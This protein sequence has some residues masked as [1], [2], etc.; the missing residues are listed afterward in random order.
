MRTTLKSLCFLLLL[1]AGGV[2]GAWAE[3]YV[4]NN[5][6]ISTN[7]T[8]SVT[9]GS[10]FTISNT[11]EKSYGNVSDTEYI[12]YSS[13]ANHTLSGIPEGE[14]IVSIKFEG[15][16]NNDESEANLTIN[17]ETQ[18]FPV[19][20]S[21][22]SHTW[23][24]TINSGE[25]L[26]FKPTKEGCFVI[27]VT[28]ESAI[29][30][31][32]PNN[33]VQTYPYTWDLSAS[34]SKWST[35]SIQLERYADWGAEGTSGTY[36]KQLYPEGNTGPYGYD[37]DVIK[38]LRFSGI[39]FIGLD[40]G[41]G[42]I[43]MTAGNITIPGLTAGQVVTL[44]MEGRGTGATTVTA[45]N[46]TEGSVSVA[47]SEDN[48][49]Y[50][51][52]T[53]TSNGDVTLSFNN[54]VSIRS[55]AV[56]EDKVYKSKYT[57][58]TSTEEIDGKIRNLSGTFEFIGDG[59]IEGGTQITDVP[60]IVMTVGRAE[61]T[62]SVEEENGVLYSKTNAATTRTTTEATAG[63]F[64]KFT[65]Y[66]NGFITLHGKS[67]GGRTIMCSP[68]AT[69]TT[70]S[71]IELGNGGVFNGNW[72]LSIPLIAGKTYYFVGRVATGEDAYFYLHGF[73]FRPAFL[74]VDNDGN[75]T[76]TE[77]S[78]AVASP[79]DVNMS[80]VVDKYPKLITP[81]AGE[82]LVKFAGSRTIV[83]LKA[84]N[85]VTLL[86]EG[87]TIIKGTVLKND[88]SGDELFTYY[89]LKS[90]VLKLN[91]EFEDQ[92]YIDDLGSDGK[93]EFKN[94]K[95]NSTDGPMT[96]A[97]GAKVYIQ[98]GADDPVEYTL[99]TSDQSTWRYAIYIPIETTPGTTYRI[100][101]PAGS[102]IQDNTG[103]TNPEIVRTFTINNGDFEVP[104]KMIYPTGV[105]TVGTSI[106]LET[107][108]K[109][110][111]EQYI[112]VDPNE[113]VQGVLKAEDDTGDGMT[114]EASFSSNRLVF[115]PTSPLEPNTKYTLT[116][117]HS[118]TNEITLESSRIYTHK[119][120]TIEVDGK[121]VYVEYVCKV[122]K[123]K[124]FT[125]T[126][127]SVSG[128]NP[129][130]VSSWPANSTLEWTL[131]PID[132][133]TYYNGG[134]ISF[135]FDQNIEIE[136]YSIINVT[137]I[138]G[139]EATVHG[140][141]NA[142]ID[143]GN[144]TINNNTLTFSYSKDE[145]KYDLYYE[146]V[147][148]VNTVIGA[149]GKPNAEEIKI[150]F[151]MGK[152]PNATDVDASSFYPH[153]WDFNKFGN[154]T[155]IG[156][157]AYNIKNYHGGSTKNA[158]IKEGNSYHSNRANNAFD[159][160]ANIYYTL[161]GGDTDAMDEFGGIRVSLKKVSTGRFEI[162]NE[163][164]QNDDG[165]DKWVFRMNG[166][167]HYMTLSNVPKGKLYMV[168]N[169][170]HIGINSPNATFESVSGTNFTLSNS[171]TLMT[172]TDGSR[173]V[174]INM[175]TAG[176][177]SFCVKDFNCEKIAVPVCY[178]TF[179]SE[180]AVGGK[181]YATDCQE[182][183]IRHDLVNAFTN[184]NV[185]AYYVSE[186]S[187]NAATATELTE[188][189]TTTA[190]SAA[191]AGTIVVLQSAATNDTEI[192]FFKTDVNTAANNSTNLL[193]GTTT[194]ITDF[195]NT[196]GKKYFFSNLYKLLNTGKTGFADGTDVDETTS[197]F[198]KASQMG[199]Y[200]AMGTIVSANKAW[201]DLSGSS[202]S[203]SYYVF[204]FDDDT[205]PTGVNHLNSSR[206]DKEG[207]WRTLQGVRVSNPT[208][209]NLY[210]HNGKKVF[211]K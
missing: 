81:E 133:G 93:Y 27:T 121:T 1:L 198:I 7:E 94:A 86:D 155:T 204:K 180:F 202:S 65:P 71:K 148:P 10:G 53:V 112:N 102:L 80:L 60:G 150:Y 132:A 99:S 64:Y 139:S 197:G 91:S 92:A 149:G 105:A 23:N 101:I 174:V 122:T 56:T 208:R 98:E 87:T 12:K 61:D 109:N 146:A 141:V 179:K 77:P 157:T 125:F 185:K 74:V 11:G 107:Y 14:K 159:Q 42:H 19:K 90:N 69:G 167:T 18:T 47:A 162:R 164:T 62:W 35:S 6:S 34:G 48:H 144:I 118:D 115:K 153:T 116:I 25:T 75:I 59:S 205:V 103:A 24:I 168:V 26:T 76:S 187:D 201:L 152:N 178:K 85:D 78:K 2:N 68:N 195:S 22:A 123:D 49:Q 188:T 173:K 120:E 38:G 189:T 143:S 73:T 111:N 119:D 169:S 28:T 54:N 175:K 88:N 117:Y 21:T 82:G 83:N 140:N 51:T 190:T 134:N 36:Y 183:E 211:I 84:N 9:F 45:T 3:V 210:I 135:T 131:N 104:I 176:D 200:R 194:E 33:T 46:T 108:M 192:P 70:D 177:V 158:L 184:N 66:V 97:N 193:K 44:F 8:G 16:A 151:K 181:T 95:D 145:L 15:Y 147:I 30:Y 171:N 4:L 89:Y 163:G 100:T 17:G 52:F 166:N 129:S 114:I 170:K 160:G 130:L 41:Y 209:G 32:Y 55:I 206:M 37:I 207:E 165:T 43:W 20:G 63:N 5:T 199:F 72:N 126:T 106:V 40:W 203:R 29:S 196:D 79:Y 31:S 186:T 50:Y 13:G 67:V 172:A 39:G 182:K 142:N 136:P 191:K 110:D 138:N 128:N 57:P 124:T 58:T 127:G 113:K 137:P 96:L 161:N 154:A 156:T